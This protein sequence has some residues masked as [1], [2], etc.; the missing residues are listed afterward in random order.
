MDMNGF[1]TG[2]IDTFFIASIFRVLSE[3]KAPRRNPSTPIDLK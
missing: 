2:G 3:F 1:M